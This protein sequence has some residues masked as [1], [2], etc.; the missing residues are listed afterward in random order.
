M[1][2]IRSNTTRP[3][4]RIDSS[5]RLRLVGYQAIFTEQLCANS[6]CS[7]GALPVSDGSGY[8]WRLRSHVI[9]RISYRIV[10]SLL[11]APLQCRSLSHIVSLLPRRLSIA[12]C[13]LDTID[14]MIY[15][16][17]LYVNADSRSHSS[18]VCSYGRCSIC[19]RSSRASIARLPLAATSSASVPVSHTQ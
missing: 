10:L 17:L 11:S 19:S 5:I 12:L 15:I 6:L 3:S 9:Y 18:R 1:L 16:I 7:I 4:L 13:S 14:S 2:L 8:M